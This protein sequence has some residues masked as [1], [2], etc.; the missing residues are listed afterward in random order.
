MYFYCE[1]NLRLPL[2]SAISQFLVLMYVYTMSIDNKWI[3]SFKKL[4]K[5]IKTIKEAL[6][7]I[8]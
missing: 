6:K 7:I 3:E 1:N 4:F 8:V 5:V 2:N